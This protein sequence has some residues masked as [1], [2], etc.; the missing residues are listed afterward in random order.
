MTK[1]M[2]KPTKFVPSVR[3]AKH[4]LTLAIRNEVSTAWVHYCT[5]GKSSWYIAQRE[6]AVRILIAAVRAECK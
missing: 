2:K 1:P 3:R 4:D 6:K 5:V